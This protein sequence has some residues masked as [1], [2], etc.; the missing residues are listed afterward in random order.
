MLLWALL[1]QVLCLRFGRRVLALPDL[2]P[3]KR[4]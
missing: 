2:P 1:S 4:R 3:R